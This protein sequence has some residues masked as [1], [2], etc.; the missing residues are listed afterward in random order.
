M[1]D[2][3]LR[4]KIRKGGH[5]GAMHYPVRFILF[6]CLINISYGC[7]LHEPRPPAQDD[8]SKMDPKAVIERE[9]YVKPPGPPPFSEKSM[10]ANKGLTADTK[11][12][13]MIFNNAAL[14]DVLGAVTND[15]DL[16]LSIESEIDLEK[17][18]TVRLK[19]VTLEEALDMVVVKGA[20]YAWKIEKGCLNIQ[21]F[22]QLIYHLD[23]LDMPGQV[24]IEV[25]GDMLASSVEDAGVTGK[26][27]IR[28]QQSRE[29]VGVWSAIRLSLEELKSEEGVLRINRKAGIIYMEDKPK[30]IGSMVRYLDSLSESICR[31]VFIEASILEV[32]LS[33]T[34]KYGIDWSTL[35]VDFVVN[36]DSLKRKLPDN[37]NIGLNSGS[38][39]LAD[40][41]SVNAT[42]DFLRTQGDITVLSNPHLS[43]MNGQSAVMTVGYQFPY[44]DIDGV[45]R[46]TETGVITYGTS[47]KRA[48]LGLQLGITPQISANGIVTLHIVPTI[49]RIQRE[50]QVEIPTTTTETQSISNPV[51]DLQ[52]LVTTVRVREGR[53]VVLAGLIS[54]S[55]DIKDEGLP[56]LGSVPLLG[57]LFKHREE[58]TAN[59]E[60]VIFITP[61]IKEII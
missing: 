36:S 49:T 34:C 6:L 15:T 31:Q 13:S 56:W 61:H 7:L 48:I 20:G 44:G 47:I 59:R 58:T 29:S 50:E 45:D 30:R 51:I 17:T 5:T 10:P 8:L 19:N 14:S 2:K 27:R 38:V 4:I 25:G 60:L 22:E 18:V 12:Y 53:T 54:Q 42:L 35:E 24:D 9:K 40:E 39:V 1:G 57:Y 28:A 26:Y 37:L 21:R 55:R 11:L 46:D 43:V 16:N 32:R 52:E 33:D 41:S 3:I 23:Y